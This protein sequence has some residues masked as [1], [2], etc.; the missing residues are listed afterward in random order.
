MTAVQ[1]E[2][3]TLILI[4]HVRY[5]SQTFTHTRTGTGTYPRK[6]KSMEEYLAWMR[7]QNPQKKWEAFREKRHTSAVVPQPGCVDLNM[8]QAV[9]THQSKLVDLNVERLQLPLA[10]LVGVLGEQ[11]V[12]LQ[13]LLQPVHLHLK[14]RV[15]AVVQLSHA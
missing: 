6:S 9:S 4:N 3:V 13:V 12:D 11:L 14:T 1:M 10:D 15:E 7:A 2:I 5:L 8:N